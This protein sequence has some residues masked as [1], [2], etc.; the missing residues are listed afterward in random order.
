[1][2]DLGECIDP[3]RLKIES[4]TAIGMEAAGLDRRQ[5]EPFYFIERFDVIGGEGD[6]DNDDR[7]SLFIP[8]EDL[9]AYFVCVGLEPFFRTEFRLIRETP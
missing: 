6:G 8:I 4:G 5:V 9:F 3:V 7:F 2:G 1:M